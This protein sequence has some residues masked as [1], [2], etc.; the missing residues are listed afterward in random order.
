MNRE[1]LTSAMEDRR[2][3]IEQKFRPENM[4]IV[5]KE[6]F[7]S[8]RDPAVTIRNG[9]ITFNTACIN[10]LED[11]VWVNLMGMLNTSSSDAQTAVRSAPS[12]QRIRR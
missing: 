2:K 5:R 6:Y 1:E 4:K 8:L 9:N 10:G 12:P 3:E 11:V 7:S